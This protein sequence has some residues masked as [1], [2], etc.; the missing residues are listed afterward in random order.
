MIE[1]KGIYPFIIMNTDQSDKKVTHWWSFLELH[2][3]KKSF[4]LIFWF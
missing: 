1:S 4:Y 2:T 3:K